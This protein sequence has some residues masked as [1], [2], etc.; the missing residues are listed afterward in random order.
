M[1]RSP[2]GLKVAAILLAAWAVLICLTQCVRADEWDGAQVAPRWAATLDKL[3]TRYQR[4]AAIYERLARLRKNGVPAPILF[5]LHYRESDNDFRAHPHEG[6]PLLHR[7]RYVPRGRLPAPA[8]PPFT[9]EQSAED[10]YY[11]ADRL[12]R[13]DWRTRLGALEAIESFNG[14]GYRRRHLPSPYVWSGTSRYT[15]GKFVADGRFD[16]LA[17]DKQAG[18]AAL[19]KRMRERGIAL[20]AAFE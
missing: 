11:V 18:V 2:T 12:D 17:I 15:R 20:P 6:S 1:S 14:M 19:L 8:E 4:S 13:K 10:A 3:V 5:A 7:T 9:F 16:P